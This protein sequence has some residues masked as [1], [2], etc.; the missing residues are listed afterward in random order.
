[1]TTVLSLAEREEISRGLALNASSRTIAAPL[2]RAPQTVSRNL[3]RHGGPAK[4]R[5]A[6]AKERA[7]DN[8]HRP[9]SCRLQSN[10][11]LRDPVA[12]KLAADLSPQLI[13][14]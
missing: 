10:W 1:M 8:A 6:V 9:K 14:G 2:E 7:R 13:F 4:Y 3:G 11:A 5:A 12:D